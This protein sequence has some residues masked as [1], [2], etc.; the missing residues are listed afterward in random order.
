MIYLIVIYV[1][2]FNLN[3]YFVIGSNFFLVLSKHYHVAVGLLVKMKFSY[4]IVIS[5][6]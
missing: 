6:S 3:P 4:L 5:E 1:D 2:T